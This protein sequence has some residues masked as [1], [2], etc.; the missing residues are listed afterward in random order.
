MEF[1]GD[2]VGSPGRLGRGHSFDRSVTPPNRRG[3]LSHS[4]RNGT[5][6]AGSGRKCLADDLDGE[7]ELDLRVEVDADFVRAY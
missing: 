7:H 5:R 4:S 2:P 3:R 1:L 6:C